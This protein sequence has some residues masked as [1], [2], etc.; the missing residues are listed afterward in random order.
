M[1]T[2]KKAS[3]S[4]VLAVIR[5]PA[6]TAVSKQLSAAST[7][8]AKAPHVCIGERIGKHLKTG[9]GK[10][11]ERQSLFVANVFQ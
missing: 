4:K 3:S 1:E 11:S 8:Y 6:A 2:Q 10:Q 9:I 7:P 5:K